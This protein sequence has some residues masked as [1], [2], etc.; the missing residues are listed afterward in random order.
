MNLHEPIDDVVVLAHFAVQPALDGITAII[1]HEYDGLEPEAHHRRKLLHRQLQ[2][3]ITNEQDRAAQLH[4]A[5]RKSS[6]KGA[7]YHTTLK[8]LHLMERLSR[9]TRTDSPPDAAP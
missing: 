1:E 9:K 5:R 7:S 3:P 4:I 2:A 8:H 6:P